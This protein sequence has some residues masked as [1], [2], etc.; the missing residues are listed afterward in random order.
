MKTRERCYTCLQEFAQQIVSLSGANGTLV[1]RCSHLIDRLY[2]PSKSTTEISNRLL[3][4]IREQTGVADPF[5]AKKAMELRQAKVAAEEFRSLFP[6]DLEGLLKY[7]CLG[8]SLDYFEGSYDVSGF[9]FLGNVESIRERIMNA[10]REALLFGDNIGDFFF[11]LP[12]IRFL[13][14]AGKN[15]YYAVKEAPAQNDLSMPDVELYGLR[16]LFANIISTGADEVGMRKERMAGT[17]KALWESDALVIAKGMGN[18]EA[19]S[20]FHDE[21]PVIYNLKVKCKTVAEA[22]GR[23]VGEHTSFIGGV[24]GS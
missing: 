7:S 11:D 12:L 13:E 22:L 3:G 15:V 5:A 17:I 9:R 16:D 23:N 24:Y 10:G 2:S 8:N 19:I 6:P 4:Y 1:E 18:Y 20:E 21:R 14:S